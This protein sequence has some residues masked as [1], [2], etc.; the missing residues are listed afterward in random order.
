MFRLKN[1]LV[2][3]KGDN[4]GEEAFHLA[5]GICKQNKATLYVLHVIEVK[6]E[7]PLDSA[8]DPSYGE[9]VLNRIEALGAEKKCPVA[10]EYVQARHSGP[11]IVQE[12]LERKIDLIILGIPYKR[13]FGQFTLG[14]TASYVLK[15]ASCPVI[16]WREQAAFTSPIGS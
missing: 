12:A 2:P 9:S 8:V 14:E 1:V 16:L 4:I 13:R 5:C 15:N 10:A 11:A 6:Q 3:T 7:L